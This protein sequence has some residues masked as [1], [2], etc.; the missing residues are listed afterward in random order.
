LGKREVDGRFQDNCSAES[1]SLGEFIG[2]KE[3]L[4]SLG[5]LKEGLS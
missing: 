5:L 2:E 3:R 4:D 1:V